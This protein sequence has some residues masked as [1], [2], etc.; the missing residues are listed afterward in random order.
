MNDFLMNAGIPV[1]VY[2]NMVTFR[3]SNRSFELDGDLLE[4][5]TNYDFNVSI[6]NPQDRK[7]LYECGNK[8]ILIL[9]NDDEKLLEL[10]L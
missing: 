3:D 2:D 9:D 10:N 4:T 5:M 1:S 7:L 8:C 6:S